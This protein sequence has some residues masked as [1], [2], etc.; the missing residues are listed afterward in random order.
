MTGGVKWSTRNCARSLNLIIRTNGICTTQNPS[1]RT[2]RRLLWDFEIQTNHLISARPPDLVIICQKKK[3]NLPNC[4]LC[5]PAD[6]RVKLKGREKKDKYLDL[7]RKLTKTVEHEND[8]YNSSNWCSHQRTSTRTRGLGNK[9]TNGGYP[10]NHMVEIS[11]N[12]E[13]SPEDFRRLAVT[14]VRNHRLTLVGK[15]RK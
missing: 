7:D 4:G 6:L 1:W 15:N 12:T 5:C 14:C 11:Q 9:R 10:S 3:E 8:N 13:K 2:R